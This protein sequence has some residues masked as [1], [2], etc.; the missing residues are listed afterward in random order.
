VKIRRRASSK[1]QL[2][3][4]ACTIQSCRDYKTCRH[5]HVKT[6]QMNAHLSLSN[7]LHAIH[8]GK[9]SRIQRP[10][11]PA[12]VQDTDDKSLRRR[13][14]PRHTEYGTFR[15]DVRCA[16]CPPPRLLLRP[17]FCAASRSDLHP[18]RHTSNTEYKVQ[19]GIAGNREVL[20]ASQ[21]RASLLLSYALGRFL[22]QP[23]AGDFLP[24]FP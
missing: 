17:L 3:S 10:S 18:D 5:T 22:R 14:V 8:P 11:Y 15:L 1:Y 13:L 19:P 20:R 21:L 7:K 2:A 4:G 12:P 24:V 9:A 16:R 6:G 23:C